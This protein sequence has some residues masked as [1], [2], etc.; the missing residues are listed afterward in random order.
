[1]M[2]TAAS[3]SIMIVGLGL[4]ACV[5]MRPIPLAYDTVFGRSPIRMLLRS[6]QRRCADLLSQVWLELEEPL[7]LFTN[8]RVDER[9]VPPRWSLID[10][11]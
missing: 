8:V 6:S 7:A 5:C 10:N 9:R 11:R 3:L 4:T 2:M 1:M